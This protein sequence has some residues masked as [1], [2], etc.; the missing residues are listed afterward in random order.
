MSRLRS[1]AYAALVIGGG[2]AL[3]AAM[4]IDGL[5]V[6]GRHVGVP[7]LGSIEAVQAAVLVAGTASM[8]IATIA[9]RHARV[10][11]LVD[12]LPHRLASALRRAGFV[13]GAVVFLALAVASAWIAADLWDGF[14]ESEW[15]HIPYA[16]LR[17]I[18]ILAAVG[19][20][21]SFLAAA[22]RRSDE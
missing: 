2:A 4:S 19:V 10:N 6:V 20:A 14:E 15:L 17:V 1:R 18:T 13:L 7:L 9:Q 5:A 3:L 16:P 11:L 8:L 12:R 21:V 22:F